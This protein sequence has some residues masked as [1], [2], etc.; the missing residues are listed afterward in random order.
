[1]LGVVM[2]FLTP[3]PS[4]SPDIYETLVRLYIDLYKYTDRANSEAFSGD[5][6]AN[7]GDNVKAEQHYQYAD[8]YRKQIAELRG[9]IDTKLAVNKAKALEPQIEIDARQRYGAHVSSP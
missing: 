4:L 8:S 1:M 6:A 7:N 2:A 9:I 3:A 5:D